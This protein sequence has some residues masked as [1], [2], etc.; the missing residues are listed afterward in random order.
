MEEPLLNFLI[1]VSDPYRGASVSVV[2][3]LPMLVTSEARDA[4]RRLTVLAIEEREGLWKPVVRY[5]GG[6]VG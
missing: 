6:G 4:E 5:F 3:P 1:E 2:V